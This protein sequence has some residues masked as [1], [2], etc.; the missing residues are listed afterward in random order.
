MLSSYFKST[1]LQSNSVVRFSR[2]IDF[3]YFRPGVCLTFHIYKNLKSWEQTES[4]TYFSLLN[5]AEIR[6][7]SNTTQ[8]KP[9]Q[10]RAILHWKQYVNVLKPKQPSR[11]ERRLSELARISVLKHYTCLPLSGEILYYYV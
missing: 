10:D 7:E 5:C 2:A 1:C 9:Q 6:A 4:K 11:K 3:L 8:A